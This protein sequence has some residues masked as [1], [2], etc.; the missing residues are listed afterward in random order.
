MYWHVMRGKF[1]VDSYDDE[2]RARDKCHW[3]NTNTHTTAYRVC[4]GA[5]ICDACEGVPHDGELHSIE[6]GERM[7]C[8]DCYDNW[9]DM[10]A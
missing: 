7:V 4:Q 2:Q 8:I 1:I 3:R 9:R 5:L 10:Y 6:G